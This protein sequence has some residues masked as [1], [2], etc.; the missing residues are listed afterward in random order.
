MSP[1]TIQYADSLDYVWEEVT[2]TEARLA[3]DPRTGDLA[4]RFAGFYPRLDA[5]RSAQYGVWRGEIVAQAHV[6]AADEA[7]DA[8]VVAVGD[9]IDRA[10][11]DRASPRRQ[12]YLG[13]LTARKVAAQALESELKVVR[14]WPDSLATEEEAA[15]HGCA[16]PLRVAVAKGEAAVDE[17]ARSQNARK[18]FMARERAKLVDA[19]NDLRTEVHAELAKRVVPNKLGREW[20]AGFFRKG[21]SSRAAKGAEEKA[22]EKAGGAKPAARPS[23]APQPS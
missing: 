12:R 11:D 15:L 17:R 19:L 9:E 6:D 1:R 23:A 20:P 7:L 18:D 4:P 22:D 14:A 13:P 16:E 3:A 2:Y 21:P 8:C 10:G 5:V